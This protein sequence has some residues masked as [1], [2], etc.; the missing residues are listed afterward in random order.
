MAEVQL[1][2]FSGLYKNSDGVEIE[3]KES[4]VVDAYIDEFNY[5]H[6]RP[7]LDGFVDLGTGAK[8]D[9]LYWWNIKSV[10]IAVSNSN[11]YKIDVNTQTA[12]L[13]GT[14]L[15]VGTHVV[16][17][18]GT[19]SGGTNVLFM[20][21][22]GHIFYTDNSTVT[23]V[24]S[25]DTD[26]PTTCTHI[27]VMDSYLL[28]NSTGSDTI[29]FS[30]VLDPLDWR[31]EFFTAEGNVD[32]VTALVANGRELLPFGPQSIETWYNDGSTPFARFEGGET[33]NGV[34]A[35]YS[36]TY[37]DNTFYFMDKDRRFV[38]LN[39]RQTEVVSRDLQRVIQ[40]L[41]SVN[42]A[43]ADLIRVNGQDFYIIC[44][45][46][47]TRFDSASQGDTIL[48]D[49]LGGNI[50]DNTG[51][52]IED[53]SINGFTL[54]YDYANNRWYEWASW[55]GTRYSAFEYNCH[56]FC[57]AN[58][59]NYIGSN[60]DGNIYFLSSDRYDDLGTTVRTLV[61]TGF[62][63]HGTHYRKS[64]VRLSLRGKKGVNNGDGVFITIGYK[65]EE[66]SDYNDVTE[67]ITSTNA[68][69]VVR[70]GRMG[71]YRARSYRVIHTG[72][73]DLVLGDM[74]E[75]VEVTSG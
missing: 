28:A 7:C 54:V 50:L 30:Q 59:R 38:R 75:D 63:D 44:F 6:K 61:E 52:P 3:T 58:G 33:N 35:P 67:E 16:F 60:T 18:E 43:Y 46:T 5:L 17:A 66:E 13:L 47:A 42:D 4:R 31:S 62:L 24:Y 1:P 53:N 10:V 9:G 11:V 23:D 70:K 14:G 41:D 19:L 65:D 40:R 29:Y 68:N 69:F 71:M 8:V 73:C 32:S 74:I 26:S 51:S 34:V 15:T 56:C 22:G 12:T 37:I 2:L 57:I 48:T 39:G 20:A 25:V 27:V 45:P 64:S 21:N 36:I 72:A 49:H 55:D